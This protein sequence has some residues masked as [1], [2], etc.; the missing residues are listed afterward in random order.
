MGHLR[1]GD[2]LDFLCVWV[3]QVGGGGQHFF[4]VCVW[5]TLNWPISDANKGGHL[6]FR[7]K[8]LPR[9]VALLL[10]QSKRAE[11]KGC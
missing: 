9:V 11:S 1:G 8:F 5:P 7:L 3:A 6:K 2:I 4:C 10:R